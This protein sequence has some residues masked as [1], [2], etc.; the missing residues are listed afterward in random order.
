MCET[1][2]FTNYLPHHGVFNVNKPGQVRVVY[3]ASARYQGTT[4]NENVLPSLDLLN[5]L[6]SVL[7]RF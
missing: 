2:N 6:I 3:H 4:L 7:T 1:S 5:K